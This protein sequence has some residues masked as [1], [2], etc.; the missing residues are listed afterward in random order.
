MTFML[1][2]MSSGIKVRQRGSSPRLSS[3]SPLQLLFSFGLVAAYAVALT[4]NFG[5]G[6]LGATLSNKTCDSN[7]TACYRFVLEKELGGNDV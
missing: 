2:F 5:A 7:V 3:M 4:C 1:I 6:G